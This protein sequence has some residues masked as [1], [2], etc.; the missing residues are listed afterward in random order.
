MEEGVAAAE[1]PFPGGDVHRLGEEADALL[2]DV[3]GPAGRE[4]SG[5]VEA[6]LPTPVFDHVLVD[7]QQPQPAVKSLGVVFGGCRVILCRVR[8][9]SAR[10]VTSWSVW[11]VRERVR[12]S[13]P[14]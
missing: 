3:P 14:R 12:T 11:V 13:R 6:A 2:V 7:L 9:W 10:A 4:D 1:L 8:R 5:R